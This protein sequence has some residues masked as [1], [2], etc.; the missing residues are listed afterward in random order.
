MITSLQHINTSF[1]YRE[2]QIEYPMDEIRS[3]D[4]LTVVRRDINGFDHFMIPGKD[5]SVEDRMDYDTIWKG[6][7]FNILDTDGW[8]T[9]DTI[10][11]TG[12]KLS[13]GKAGR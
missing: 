13:Y 12:L 6:T 2:G 4:Y 7:T 9:G 1:G 5:Y 8:N 10:Y 3:H 11:I